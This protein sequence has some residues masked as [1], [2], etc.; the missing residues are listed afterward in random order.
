[1]HKAYIVGVGSQAY[2]DLLIGY[3]FELTSEP[4][5]A[6]IAL[7]TGGEDVTPG[8]YGAKA[9]PYTSFNT[10]RDDEE[11][12]YFKA[13]K[14]L[15][16]PMLG[17]CRG[18]QFLNVM[19]GGSMYQHVTHHTQD[20]VIMDVLSQCTLWASSTHHQMMKPTSKAVLVAVAHQHGKRQ[21][22]EGVEF[23]ED[24]SHEDIEVVYYEEA[25]CLC[26]QP[27]PEFYGER[28][29]HLREYLGQCLERFHMLQEAAVT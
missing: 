21:W 29:H 28:Y 17:I 24:V 25:K 18:G 2:R 20:H 1:M 9:H 12:A 5:K 4:L 8:L 22:Y 10:F 23:H 7:F 14:E 11:Q 3:G 26:F 19:N 15:G 27:H 13:F 16:V 6:D